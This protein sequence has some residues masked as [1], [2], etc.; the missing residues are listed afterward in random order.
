LKVISNGRIIRVRR[1]L[2]IAARVHQVA[3]QQK[4]LIWVQNH[5]LSNERMR[6]QARRG[7]SWRKTV[8]GAANRSRRWDHGE[9]AV[10]RE[11]LF[12]PEITP[13]EMLDSH[14]QGLVGAVVLD[15]VGILHLGRRRWAI[16]DNGY[17]GRGA[18]SG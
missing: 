3:T 13:I 18:I 4:E 5:G 15:V 10:R 17:R 11:I 2:G 7:G 12:G 16:G 8:I 9:P 6:K 1:P 14:A